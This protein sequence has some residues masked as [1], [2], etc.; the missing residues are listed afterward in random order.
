[1]KA[2]SKTQKTIAIVVGVAVSALALFGGEFS[3]KA[4]TV[5]N[6]MVLNIDEDALIERAIEELNEDDFFMELELEEEASETIKIYNQDYELVET[7]YLREG[8]TIEDKYTEQYL[9]QAEY[10]SSYGSTT[11]YKVFQ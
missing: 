3:S 9:N 2:T 10:L 4:D 5:H 11:I 6:E 1:M 7:I 8:E